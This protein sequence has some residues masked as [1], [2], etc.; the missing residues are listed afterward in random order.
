MV[1]PKNR[2]V[3]W[4]KTRVDD[5]NL[6]KIRFPNIIFS[7]SKVFDN[8]IFRCKTRIFFKFATRTKTRSAMVWS[9]SA[10]RGDIASLH[11]QNKY[12]HPTAADLR[13][14][15]QNGRFWHGPVPSL[16]RLR[17]GLQ[18]EPPSI[19][20]QNFVYLASLAGDQFLQ[21]MNFMSLVV[22]VHIGVHD[23]V[24]D[25]WNRHN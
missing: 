15:Q 9:K 23:K 25:I 13:H 11:M 22:Q 24:K 10:T 5:A 19:A 3:V 8:F 4:S 1:A 2:P 7:A 21:T 6:A 17:T 14:L 12:V 20:D 18:G 16:A